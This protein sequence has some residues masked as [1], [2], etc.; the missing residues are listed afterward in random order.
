MFGASSVDLFRGRLEVGG[1]VVSHKQNPNVQA[2][3]S[4]HD[5]HGTYAWVSCPR[6]FLLL[7]ENASVAP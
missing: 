3:P 1:V 7:V 4:I 5:T 6:S 2:R